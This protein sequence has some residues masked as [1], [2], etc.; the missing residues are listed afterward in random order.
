MCLLAVYSIT[1]FFFQHDNEAMKTKKKIPRNTVLDFFFQ[2]D[3]EVM[4]AKKKIP[5]NTVLDS[6]FRS[7]L[8]K[9]AFN[10]VLFR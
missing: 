5:R 6:F 7:L 4:K 8:L 9:V 1:V 2:H 3:N 10:D